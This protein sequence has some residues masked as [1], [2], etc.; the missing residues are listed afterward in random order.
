MTSEAAGVPPGSNE[1]VMLPHLEGAFSPE[2]NPQARAVFFGATLRH[3][4]AHFTRAIL[5]AVA[6]ML[7][8]NLTLVERLAGP[9]AGVRSTGGGA[10]SPLWLQIKA[11]VLQKPVTRLE[12]EETALLGAAVL[13][14]VATGAFSSPEAAVRRMVRV[15]ETFEPDPANAEV[16]DQA[17]DRYVELYERLKP[18]F[19]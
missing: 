15:G 14:A 5:E 18:M 16:Y 1:L 6:F 12:N 9:L 7:R 3:G 11:D 8:R 2:Y 10:R 13:G 19:R 17:Y 4:R